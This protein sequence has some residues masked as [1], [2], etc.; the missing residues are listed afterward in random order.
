MFQEGRSHRRNKGDMMFDTAESPILSHDRIQGS[1]QPSH[2]HRRKVSVEASM[3]SSVSNAGLTQSSQVRR[4]HYGFVEA[5]EISP[6]LVDSFTC[7]GVLDH[8]L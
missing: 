3:A 4:R 8:L 6:I 5:S 1:H 2:T 7:L